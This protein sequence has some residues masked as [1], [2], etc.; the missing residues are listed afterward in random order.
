MILTI[1]VIII[2]III[3]TTIIRTIIITCRSRYRT[4]T[5][6]NTKLL[7]TLQ[8]GLKPLS[9]IKKSSPSD[10]VRVVYT[11]LKRLIHHLRWWIGIDHA[12]WIPC[13]ELSPTWFLKNNCNGNNNQHSNNNNNNNN[14]DSKNNN[15]NNTK[16]NN[17]IISLR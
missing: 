15:N 4:P 13:L 10:A 2:T 12:A 9:N 5:T 7:L 14:N 11:P 6:P 16:S 3:I 17:V 8:N 1:K